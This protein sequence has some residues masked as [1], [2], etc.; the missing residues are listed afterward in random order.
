MSGKNLAPTFDCV[1]DASFDS[2]GSAASEEHLCGWECSLDGSSNRAAS[3]SSGPSFYG[4]QIK[5]IARSGSSEAP[6]I[7][8]QIK[9]ISAEFRVNSETEYSIKGHLVYAS[10]Y[11][12]SDSKS[13]V[14]NAYLCEVDILCLLLERLHLPQPEYLPCANDGMFFGALKLFLPDPNNNDMVHSYLVEAW[15]P[16]D[17]LDDANNLTAQEDILFL[18]KN[19]NI[20]IVDFNHSKKLAAEVELQ[21]WKDLMYDCRFL[22]AAV[23][24]IWEDMLANLNDSVH[25]A[26]Q[27]GSCG[28]LLHVM[29]MALSQCYVN[30]EAALERCQKP[31]V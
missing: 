6:F 1:A 26:K 14:R 13:F 27:S 24:K 30:L 20:E 15:Y 16:Q 5:N 3:G 29:E 19:M 28:P 31:H 8:G 2:G 18:E 21:F 9:N 7:W 11:L 23:Q 25:R 12:D 17:E 22:G 4:L 10:K